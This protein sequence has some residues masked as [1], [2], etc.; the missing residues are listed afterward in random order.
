MIVTSSIPIYIDHLL[1]LTVF[2]DIVNGKRFSDYS[3]KVLSIEGT[4]M[5]FS[6]GGL[7][8]I[9]YPKGKNMILW[10]PFI[11]KYKLIPKL[12]KKDCCHLWTIYGFVYDVVAEDYK[13]LC[14]HA[15]VNK[16]TMDTRYIVEIYSVKNQS[17]RTIPNIFSIC[18]A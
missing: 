1:I 7:V 4:I 3:I 9:T 11:R 18:V 2:F 16:N 13:V 5:L 17:W 6:C 8:F 15:I 14:F 12:Q 10:N